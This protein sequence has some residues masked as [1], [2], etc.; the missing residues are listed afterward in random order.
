MLDE[1]PGFEPEDAERLFELY[2]RSSRTAKARSGSG[3]GLYVTR[4]LIET[5]GGRVWARLRDE[6]GSEFGLELLIFASVEPPHMIVEDS[7]VPT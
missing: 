2:F 7:A 3:I 1:G 4:T 6:G 5:M